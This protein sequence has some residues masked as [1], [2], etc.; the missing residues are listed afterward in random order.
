VPDNE[1]KYVNV[2]LSD[3]PTSVQKNALVA[4]PEKRTAFFGSLDSA[5]SKISNDPARLASTAGYVEFMRDAGISGDIMAAP[6]MLKTILETPQKYVDLVTGGYHGDKTVPGTLEA[7]MGGLDAT[8]EMRKAIVAANPAGAP[9]PLVTALHHFWGIMS[10]RQP[11]LDQE[12]CWLRLVSQPAILEQ[13]QRSIDGTYNLPSAQWDDL[14]T[15]GLAAT[16]QDNKLGNNAKSNANSFD[17]MLNRWNGKWD[18]AG[19]AYATPSALESGRRFWGMN[20]GPVGIKNKVQRFVGLTFGTPGLIMDRWKFVEFYMGQFG[21]EPKDFFRYDSNGTPEDPASLYNAYGGVE[22]ASPTLSLAYYEG[23]ETALQK[24]ID[25]SRELQ[26]LLGRH[27]NVGG[28][29][30][31]GWNAIKNEAVGHSSLGLT[32]DLLK[33]NPNPT[34]ADVLALIQA[35]EYYTEG[36]QGSTLKK[37]TLKK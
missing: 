34:S 2:L 30:W 18:Q 9:P 4:T 17:L 24:A 35:N 37:F 20:A 26:Q 33:R 5:L 28:L 13:I 32:Y 10:R 1:H 8:V 21:G 29:H 23:M 11:P 27:A 3:R 19:Q 36:L 15:K 22:S 16:K 6:P 14:V 12:A 31:V 7:A 25:N